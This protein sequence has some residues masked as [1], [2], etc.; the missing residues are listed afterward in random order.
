MATAQMAK[1]LG[2]ELAVS[3]IGENLRFMQELTEAERP[4]S[5]LCPCGAAP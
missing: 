3:L 5:R 4:V 1:R 2:T